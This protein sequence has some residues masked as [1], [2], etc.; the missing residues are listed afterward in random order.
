[1]LMPAW[2]LHLAALLVGAFYLGF[3]VANAR[4]SA[5]IIESLKQRNFAWP[6]L[7]FWLGVSTQSL[8]GMALLLGFHPALSAGVLIGFTLVA[9]I[10]FHNFWAMEGEARLLNRII[11][12]CD[13]TCVLAILL[14]LASSD[15][16][17]WISLI[18]LF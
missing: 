13:Y 10:V 4:S 9:P 12:I 5:A 17:A 3:G 14:L 6:Q 2:A 11:F 8:A 15:Q 16:Q 1:M 18:Q 7:L